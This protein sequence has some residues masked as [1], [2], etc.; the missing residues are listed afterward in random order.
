MKVNYHVIRFYNVVKCFSVF[1]EGISTSK[2]MNNI[3][4]EKFLLLKIHVQKIIYLFTIGALNLNHT[5]F[6]SQVSVL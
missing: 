3:V 4:L 5:L 6:F 1:L 2:E